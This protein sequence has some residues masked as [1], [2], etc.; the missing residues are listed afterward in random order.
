MSACTVPARGEGIASM[1]DVAAVNLENLKL[2]KLKV[3]L[4]ERKGVTS[5]HLYITPSAGAR[6]VACEVVIHRAGEGDDA[7]VARFD[8]D[9]SH[10]PIPFWVSNELVDEV[11]IRYHLADG[12]GDHVFK[13]KRGGL[14]A[15]AEPAKGNP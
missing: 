15:L 4:K 5:V 2:H 7:V 1:T 10:R 3:V 13:I 6:L 14:R 9:L 11:T 12:A 8:L